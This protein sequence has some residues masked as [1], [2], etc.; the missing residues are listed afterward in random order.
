MMTQQQTTV[1]VYSLT[2]H[3]LVM[4]TLYKSV[5]YMKEIVSSSVIK[6]LD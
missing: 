6:I 5:Q 1:Q 2:Y 3:A 4:K